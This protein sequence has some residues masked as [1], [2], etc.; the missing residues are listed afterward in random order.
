M[1]NWNLPSKNSHLHELT[2]E[3]NHL[4]Y[5]YQFLVETEVREGNRVST[6]LGQKT[7]P[8]PIAWVGRNPSKYLQNSSLLGLGEGTHYLTAIF[9]S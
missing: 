5:I 7:D 2:P 6:K 9:P 8:P 4:Y 1:E 3:L